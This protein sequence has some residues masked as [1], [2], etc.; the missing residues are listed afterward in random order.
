METYTL[1]KK[2]AKK[3]PKRIAKQ[4][5]DCVGLMTGKL[6]LEVKKIV[7]CLDMDWQIVDQ[8]E[9]IKPDLVITHHP[10]IFGTKAKVFKYDISK[11]ELSDRMDAHNIPVYSFH[12]NF[13]TGVDGMNDAIAKALN[14]KN[15]YAPINNQM[16]RIGELESALDI[17]DFAK[18][19]QE[20][21]N[22]EYGLLVSNGNKE[23]KKVG[24]I[25]GGGSRSWLLAKLEGCDLYISGD[26]PH[27]V[28]RD[29]INAN[30]NYLDFPHEIEKIF[31]PQMKKLLLDIDD[32]LEVIIIDHEKA[33]TIIH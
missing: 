21:L 7:L 18:Y 26:A 19:A 10:F 22:I 33:P 29:I 2:L 11:K 8:V 1:L 13:D 23:I 4:N 14:L 28:R 32:S 12:T 25:G 24:I 27:Y 16:M 3:F 20:K 30:F 9:S 17:N 6:P 5:H 15:I 31:M